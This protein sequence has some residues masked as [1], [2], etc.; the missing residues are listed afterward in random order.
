MNKL[1]HTYTDLKKSL[2]DIIQQITISG[3]EP[4]LIIG[5]GRGAY[6][7]G[8]MLSHY[9]GCQF[10]G[11]N[12]QTR[13]GAIRDYGHLAKI[14]S[15]YQKQNILCVDDINDT[16]T[17]LLGIK[18]ILQDHIQDFENRV[19]F[20]TIFSKNT[21]NFVD[22]DYYAVEVYADDDRWIVF[23]YEEWWKQS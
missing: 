17:T 9:Y 16:G 6:V 2:A 18:Q 19:K 20:C 11:F 15:K 12:W 13:D 5:P 10:E 22:V 7:P 23:P 8:V 21:S 4:Q 3:F 1:I 14:I